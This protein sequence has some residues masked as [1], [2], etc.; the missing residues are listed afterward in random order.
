MRN[1]TIE[2]KR[3]K[4]SDEALFDIAHKIRYE[5]FV[6]EQHVD[7]DIE[8]DGLDKDCWH[9]LVFLDGKPVGTSRWRE[10]EKG[11]KLERFAVLKSARGFKVGDSMVRTMLDELK[12]NGKEL[13]LNSQDV[14]VGFY[15]KLGFVKE[16]EPF[17]EA[18]IVHY[19]MKYKG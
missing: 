5:V 16:G 12:D 18:D 17:I 11:Y 3:F 13:Y 14:A 8:F 10:T 6:I 2:I 4:S 7:N 1:N 19:L 9:Y 15:A